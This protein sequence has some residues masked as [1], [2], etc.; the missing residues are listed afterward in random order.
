MK[1]LTSMFFAIFTLVLM[2]NVASAQD[3]PSTQTFVV[4]RVG[5]NGG[6]YHYAE[7][8]QQRGK[9]IFPDVG[10]ID[11]DQAKQYREYFV[12]AGA[13]LFSSKH[14]TVIEEGY[15]DKAAGPS[16]GGVE[17]ADVPRGQDDDAG[18]END[19]NGCRLSQAPAHLLVNLIQFPVFPVEGVRNHLTDLVG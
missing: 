15:L 12:G 4:V 16:S 19:G 8:F 2:A 7:V 9:W 1:N 14:L 10:Y 13:V 3:Q 5:T 11:F 6:A 18:R 17:P